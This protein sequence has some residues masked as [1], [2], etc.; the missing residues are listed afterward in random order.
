MALGHEQR[1]L[2]RDRR[3][4]CSQAQTSGPA[5][6][7]WLCGPGRG[8][9]L[10]G[11]AFLICGES[12]CQSPSQDVS[13]PPRVTLSACAA[14][15]LGRAGLR[16]LLASV[17]VEGAIPHREQ[18]WPRP[19]TCGNVW[20]RLGLSQFYWGEAKNAV[21]HPALDRTAPRAGWF[22]PR[23]NDTEAEKP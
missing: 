19:G 10:L 8:A 16:H 3:L 12:G 23:I 11:L 4:R 14:I 18:L 15:I 22:C 6:A 13:M 17:E 7:P 1:S 9:A 5:S 21:S 20:R 2:P